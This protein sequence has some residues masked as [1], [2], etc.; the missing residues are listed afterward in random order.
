[1]VFERR[2]VTPPPDDLPVW[3]EVG[4]SHDPSKIYGGMT[5]KISNLKNTV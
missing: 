2:C 4:I 3:K 5:T 1:M